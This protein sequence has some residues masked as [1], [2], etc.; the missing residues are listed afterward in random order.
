MKFLKTL[1]FLAA[2]VLANAQTNVFNGNVQLS[3]QFSVDTFSSRYTVVTGKLQVYGPSIKNLAALSN[4]DT[5]RGK[6]EILT[7]D[8]LQSLDGLHPK[9]VG[10]NVY[11]ENNKRLR[12]ISSLQTLRYIGKDLIIL[13]CDSLKSLDGLANVDSIKGNI[14]IGTQSWTTP[15]VAK[16]NDLLDNLCA[17]SPVITSGG[18][19]GSYNVANNAWNPLVADFTGG[20]CANPVFDGNVQLGSQAQID[21]FNR[22]YRVI[23]GKLQI[24]GA[25]PKNLAPLSLIDTVRGKLEILTTDS[26]GSLDSLHIKYVGSNVYLEDNRSLQNINGLQGLRYIGKDL[27]ILNCDKLK[28]LDGLSSVDSIVGSIYIGTEAW[29]TPPTVKSNDS[30]KNLCGLTH[31]ITTNGLVGAYHVANNAYNPLKTDYAVNKCK[32]PLVTTSVQQIQ[33]AMYLAYNNGNDFVVREASGNN[34]KS[35]SL[36]NVNGQLVYRLVAPVAAN[37]VYKMD[38]SALSA[39]LYILRIEDAN[40]GMNT[41][42]VK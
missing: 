18:H 42:L 20:Y 2:P 34:I 40:G 5:V 23:T 12:N 41:K 10:N 29:K 38:H 26:L 4:I 1:L 35:L 25:T 15:V 9:Y 36:Y 30:L 24:Y 13:D 8:S 21:A 3:T 14:Y 11:F 17:L 19:T 37:G 39:G 7:T 16:S 33:P 28:T 22:Q 31:V 6:L 32:A 27:V